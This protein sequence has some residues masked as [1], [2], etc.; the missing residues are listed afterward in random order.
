VFLLDG[1]PA[2]IG[3]DIDKGEASAFND[4]NIGSAVVREMV[5]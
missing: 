3:V 2:A 1:R 4:P 5:R